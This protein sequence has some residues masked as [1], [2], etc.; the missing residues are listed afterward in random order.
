MKIKG[1]DHVNIIAVDLEQTV[2]FYETV[3][4]MKVDSIPMSPRGFEGR[5]IYDHAG[6][7][8]IHLQAYNPERHG[9]LDE[10][11][12]ASGALDHVALGCSG[13]KSILSRCEELGVN[14]R[15]ND[16]QYRNLRQ[17]FITD[18][19]NIKLELNF[20]DD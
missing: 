4:G 3:L 17:V 11:G 12:K 5:W 14:V 16:R 2:S 18:P 13:F 8:I 6:A 20:A 1:V 10:R 19:N 15:V 9:P 7:A